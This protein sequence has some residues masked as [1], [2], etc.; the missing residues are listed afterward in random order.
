LPEQLS[1]ETR[2]IL[3]DP[4]E[5]SLADGLRRLLDAPREAPV[6]SEN[7]DRAWRDMAASLMQQV[8][9][10]ALSPAE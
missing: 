7:P 4:D 5:M 1:G 2:A 6:P 10:L 9:A 8:A 3:C